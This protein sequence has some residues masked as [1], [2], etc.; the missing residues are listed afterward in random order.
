[1]KRYLAYFILLFSTEFSNAQYQADYLGDGFEMQTIQ[2]KNDYEGKVTISIIRKRSSIP[3]K[4]A[5]LYIHGFNDYFFQKN[6]AEQFI[7][8][9]YDFYAIDLRKYGRS[10]LPNQSPNTCRKL[11]EYFPDIDTA[12]SIIKS[13]GHQSIVI[14]AHSTGGL[15]TALYA[16]V[17]KGK[18]KFDRIVLNSPFLDMNSSGFNEAIAIPV[19]SFFGNIIP[20]L[21]I[22]AGVSTVYGESI[23]KSEHGVWDY[24]LAWKPLKA[25]SMDAGWL[26]AIHKGHRIIKKEIHIQKPILIISSDNSVYTKKWSEAAGKGDAVLDVKDIQKYADHL[27]SQISKAEIPNALHDLALSNLASREAYFKIMFD[28]LK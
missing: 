21:P 7:Q 20:S 11:N 13:E 18:E 2:M 17:N 26:K 28:W 12:L 15:I 14:N 23:H 27:G 8:H 1:M 24:N 19:F 5:V 3:S 16:T 4:K 25:F 22:P 10:I 6:L 9:G